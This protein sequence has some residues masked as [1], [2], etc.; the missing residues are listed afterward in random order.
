MKELSDKSFLL[1]ASHWIHSWLARLWLWLWQLLS[2]TT[3]LVKDLEC[4][5][6]RIHQMNGIKTMIMC[7]NIPKPTMHIVHTN[8][9]SFI[10]MRCIHQNV[11]YFYIS[12]NAVIPCNEEKEKKTHQYQKCCSNTRI[13]RKI[14]P[15]VSSFSHSLLLFSEQPMS[16]ALLL[17]L[18][19]SWIIE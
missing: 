19:Y 9:H 6:W 4:Q 1:I 16:D 8:T 3:Y 13:S 2:K 14:H 7:E 17:S 5:I 12:S 15:F 11:Q 18:W 10:R